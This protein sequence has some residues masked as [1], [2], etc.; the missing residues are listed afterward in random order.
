MK[1]SV[2]FILAVLLL[3]ATLAL[4]VSAD[5]TED[6]RCYVFWLFGTV[7]EYVLD[8]QKYE[9]GQIPA[10]PD[11]TPTKEDPTRLFHFVR[12]DKAPEP[13]NEKEDHY[14]YYA[15]YRVYEKKYAMNFDTQVTI[16]DVAVLLDVLSGEEV[17][18]LSNTDVSGEGV[19]SIQDVAL[20]LDY[21]AT[22]D[23]TL[24]SAKTLLQEGKEPKN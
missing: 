22:A 15:M 23:S 3:T 9:V 5:I 2:S 21:I 16:A 13:V 11:V 8:V 12:W 24:V 6:K 18:T 1:R 14:F 10:V 4:P 20:L 17:E 7:D 19:T